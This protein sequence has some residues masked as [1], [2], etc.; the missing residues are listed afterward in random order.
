[1][2]KYDFEIDQKLFDK[3]YRK[4]TQGL[5]QQKARKVLQF[6][7]NDGRLHVKDKLIPKL[8]V[9][10]KSGTTRPYTRTSARYKAN[11][12]GRLLAL[13]YINREQADYLRNAVDSKGAKKGFYTRY[14]KS[15]F[16]L[17][18]EKDFK[19]SL[20]YGQPN[21]HGGVVKDKDFSLPNRHGGRTLFK[22]EGKNIIAKWHFINQIRY[23]R[24]TFKFYQ[25]LS[26]WYMSRH[27]H[28]TKTLSK[29]VLKEI[30]K[31]K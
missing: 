1:M 9:V 27:K 18:P 3:K 23:K 30:N 14:P 22:R 11:Y 7:G 13:I 31:T 16:L 6:I 17:Y 10:K 24:R 20:R 28:Y 12:K 21:K 4:L 29:Y 8:D 26:S 15:K 5:I 2:L 19:H 25:G